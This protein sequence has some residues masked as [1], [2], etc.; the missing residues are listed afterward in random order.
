MSVLD[1]DPW[2]LIDATTD[3]P[4]KA[5]ESVFAVGN[6]FVGVR[7]RRDE[8]S[9]APTCF[10]NGFYE[11]WAIRYPETAYGLAREGQAMQA[12]PDP[13]RVHLVVD[14]QRLGDG[15]AVA[16]QRV[17]DMAAGTLTRQTTWQTPAGLVRVDARR[18]ASFTRRGLVASQ[19]DVTPVG[20]AAHIELGHGLAVPS[21][22]P[23]AAPHDPRGGT[24]LDGGTMSAAASVDGDDRLK[25]NVRTKSAGVGLTVVV[26]HC[27]SGQPDGG[28]SSPDVD[29]R[30]NQA[31]ATWR[32]DV[33]ADQTVRLTVM[34]WFAM[35]ADVGPLDIEWCQLAGEQKQWLDDFWARA[36]V[37]V[38]DP[39]LQQAIHWSLFQAIQ[40]SA[41]ADGQGIGAKGVTG[42]GYDGHYFWDMEMY[43]LPFLTYTHPAAARAA[44]TFRLATLPRAIERAQELHLAGA[45]YPWRTIN[46]HEASAYYEAGTAQYHI[47]ADI[48]HA[49]THYVA[50]TGDD[51]LMTAGGVDVLIETARMWADRGFWA[52]DGRYHIHYVTGPDEYSALVDDNVYTNLMARGNLRW[53]ADAVERWTG[54]AS[55]D[56]VAK[57]RRIADG[58]FVP[59]DEARGL[60]PQDAH[61]LER[62][63]WDLSSIPA[64]NFP[65]LLHYH[66]LTIYRHQVLK[67]ADV[68]LAQ[69]LCPEEFTAAQRRANFDYY[70]RLTTGDSTLSAVPQAIAAADV[71]YLDLAERYLRRA[72]FVDL[73]DSHRNSDAGVH[74]AVAAGVWSVLVAGFGG[75]R[76][77]DGKLSLW[78]R[79]P[80][81]W[82]QLQ[83][84][85]MW[86][87]NHLRVEATTDR[88]RL[89]VDGPSAVELTVWGQATEVAPGTTVVVHPNWQ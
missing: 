42:P 86:Q 6:G 58:M 69:T 87:G 36:D 24:V 17:L 72:A 71:G 64:G 68:V 43:V 56:E 16:Q 29:L 35:D 65:L 37:V 28:S 31:T 54:N 80:K 85:L 20:H 89:T 12:A 8:D 7:G 55:V 22:G 76:D 26:R 49:L 73:T 14:G 19:F 33:P 23:N 79:L 2:R 67:Q 34:A 46:G 32:V 52:D 70:D 74:L 13:T 39:E 62:E 82:T 77:I 21:C 3:A 50:A 11:S 78:P 66:P 51:E 83:F 41:R 10:V 15:P 27:L 40:A 9:A 53:A 57:W 60:H 88:V 81:G 47:D 25:M 38:D 5:S 4:S 75:M 44:L 48:A 1:F 61:F 18:L 45:L 63:H 30:D 84:S 59:Y